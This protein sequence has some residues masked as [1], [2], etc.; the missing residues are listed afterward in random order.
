MKPQTP[1]RVLISKVNGLGDLVVFLPTIAALRTL[2]PD[3]SITVMVPNGLGVLVRGAVSVDDV[4]EVP[5]AV[6]RQPHH[7]PREYLSL[8][9]RL[10]TMRFDFAL[11]SHDER[12]GAV[13]LQRLAGVP[14]RVGFVPS[15]RAD[16]L[17]THRVVPYFGDSMIANDLQLVRS[18]AALI[19]APVPPLAIP[20]WRF[21]RGSLP[22]GL[23]AT[24]D[25]PLVV[26][27]PFAKYAYKTWPTAQFSELIQKLLDRFPSARVAVL[28]DGGKIP[29]PP[30]PRVCCLEGL[31]TAQLLSFIAGA[32]L[33]IGNNSG[34]ANVAWFA[35][36]PTIVLSGPSPLYWS[37]PPRPGVSELRGEAA[38]APCE[39]PHH[40]PGSC[41]NTAFP[42]QCLTTLT[43]ARVADAA[44]QAI[45]AT[46]F[47]QVQGRLAR[48]GLQSMCE[49]LSPVGA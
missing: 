15:C 10:R 40:I 11:N 29:L 42:R 8:V 26:V 38:C 49:S 30:S 14:T 41:A 4:L 1:R 24:A 6:V 21:S 47:E 23:T 13:L 25:S 9:R 28:A 36:T 33:V 27:H 16:R 34:P 17:L 46:T 5:V 35:G 45:G 2:L 19:D 37:P 32:T 39:G 48:F 7:H 22:L 20:E 44:A 3:A 18:V 43:V 12:S 31:N